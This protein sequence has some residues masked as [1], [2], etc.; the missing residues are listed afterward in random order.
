MGQRIRIRGSCRICLL[1]LGS[2]K[3]GGGRARGGEED[4]G[5]RK[6]CVKK[7][8]KK[9]LERR[10]SFWTGTCN[11]CKPVCEGLNPLHAKNFSLFF[12]FPPSQARIFFLSREHI[13]LSWDRETIPGNA[14]RGAQSCSPFTACE[15]FLKQLSLQGGSD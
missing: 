8:K 3:G 7:E 1:S 5:G 11:I 10:E 14:N 2:G 6:V 15:D 13:L 9:S 12:F 4:G